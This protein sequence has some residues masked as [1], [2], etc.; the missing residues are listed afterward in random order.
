M[1]SLCLGLVLPF[2]RSPRNFFVVRAITALDAF[3]R[4]RS[5]TLPFPPSRSATLYP[6]SAR[7]VLAFGFC[8]FSKDECRSYLLRC[9][10]ST[11][12]NNLPPFSFP[13]P[14]LRAL[15]AHAFSL[16]P[17]PPRLSISFRNRRCR[18]SFL[19]DRYMFGGGLVFFFSPFRRGGRF[20][21]RSFALPSSPAFFAFP[22]DLQGAVSL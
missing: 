18:E 14:T 22:P 17:L 15:P 19:P 2:L 5:T 4:V 1:L 16:T 11:S 12:S 13:L 7:F 10:F 3:T 6:L 20:L 21:P 9:F 8:S